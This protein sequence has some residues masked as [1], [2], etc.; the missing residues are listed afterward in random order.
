MSRFTVGLFL[1]WLSSPYHV[2]VVKGAAAGCRARGWDLMC[3]VSGRIGCRN[4]LEWSRNIFLQFLDSPRF[5]AFLFLTPSL[6]SWE[7]DARL[8][9]LVSG[10]SRP[11]VS[12]GAPLGTMP[13]VAFDN[14][15]GFSA[16]LR[17]L[18]RDHG[19]R[20]VAFLRGPLEN[21]EMEIRYRLFMEEAKE[22][23][24]AQS[25]V[26][27]FPTS[28]VMEDGVGVARSLL[29][30]RER[31]SRFPVE[32]IVGSNDL[33][34]LGALSALWEAGVRVPEEL[35][36][37]GY[38]D[39]APSR[40][41]GLTSVRQP[42]ELLGKEGC[43]LLHLLC[44]GGEARPRI[45]PTG[46]VMRDSCGCRWRE[47]VAEQ[48]YRSSYLEE[49]V[50][51]GVVSYAY[52]KAKS[53]EE[54]IISSTSIP[55]I[56][57]KL[58]THLPELG[59]DCC[60]VATYD[61]PSDPLKGASLRF[62][63][64]DE[65]RREYGEGEKGLDS[66]L[67]LPDEEWETLPH[68]FVGVLHALFKG[69]E[70]I[71]YILFDFSWENVHVYEGIRHGVSVGYA[72]ARLVRELSE[73]TRILEVKSEALA[74]SNETLNREIDKRRQV[75]EELRKR[76][77]YF[78]EMALFLPVL[79]W[80]LDEEGMVSFANHTARRLIQKK[81]LE[82]PFPFL[83]L[84]EDLDQEHVEEFLERIKAGRE[85]SST[86]FRIA[87]PEG[88]VHHVLAQGGP[89]VHEGR[90]GGVRVV[91]LEVEPF[92]SSIIMPE[93]IFFSHYHFTPREKEVLLLYIQGY[94]R[95]E[96]A[97]RLGIS[98]NTVKVHLSSIYN[99]VGVSNRDDFFK[100]LK[101]YQVAQVGYH[102][103]LFSVLSSLIKGD[104]GVRELST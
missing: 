62:F 86:Q 76:E 32:V 8:Q 45:I 73:K 44:E 63:S 87:T 92:L 43:E 53:L 103:F 20:R 6:I 26:W 102:S 11:A 72:V 77:H 37:T 38:D 89:I 4:P 60:A 98:E 67:L 104:D 61:A 1:D 88:V 14:R 101:E 94:S 75:E 25:D 29:E 74:R 46:M 96:I 28:L 95:K 81:G 21:P 49:V 36:V 85:V 13:Y 66:R 48:G 64:V 56:H 100:V 30:E 52:E 54:E 99:E 27:V 33:V 39:L 40:F 70:H 9:E 69:E 83:M 12:L 93:E 19:Y 35:A 68:P 18:F 71:G 17:H 10:L 47:D 80:E 58:R 57:E 5:D 51:M 79:I 15:E 23:G 97:K 3:V 90:C 91:G 82:S 50:E 16:L 22:V 78:R 41:V 84:V 24:I 55:Q 65:R 59:I 42:P 31:R 2:N 7:G 34:A